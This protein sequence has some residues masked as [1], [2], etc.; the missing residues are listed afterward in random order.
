MATPRKIG[1]G[2]RCSVCRHEHLARIDLA[3]ASGVAAGT[4]ARRF[5]LG[6]RS[7]ARHKKAHLSVAMRSSLR[8]Q[9]QRIV[10][11]V[12]SLK[13]FESDNWL[14]G[15]VSIRA[16]AL[17]LKQAAEAVGD[18]SAARGAL[19][20]ALKSYEVEG[21]HLGELGN[22]TVTINH[23]VTS[24]HWVALRARL[25]RALQRHPEAL[26]DVMEAFR[27]TEADFVEQVEAD[28]RAM[29]P[30]PLLNGAVIHA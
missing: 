7:V 21:K 22:S 11:D 16:Q 26:Q 2:K 23:V 19:Q 18:N 17:A 8:A 28:R 25:M 1:A 20:V 5:R 13:Q 6:A 3:I 29:P 27:T 9:T 4:I 15:V 14:G 12:D 30:P 10:A 24:P